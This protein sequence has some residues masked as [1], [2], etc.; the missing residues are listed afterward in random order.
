MST[1][2]VSVPFEARDLI[3]G[4]VRNMRRMIQGATDDLWDFR[5]A[6]GNMFDNFA[7]GS[8]RARESVEDLGRRINNAQDESRRLGNT[9]IDDLFRRARRGA[10]DLRS[11]I[12]RTDREIRGL[13]NK[14]IH[15][16][17]RDEVSPVLDNISSKMGTI[18][19]AASTLILGGGMKSAMFGGVKDYHAS[20]AR[21]AP[22]LTAADRDQGLSTVDELYKQGLF[23]SRAEGANQL[24]DAASLVQDKS[25][26]SDFLSQSAKMQKLNPDASPEEVN[27]ALAQATNVFKES[28]ESVGDS[29]MYARKNVGDRQQ[30]LNDTY[31]EYSGYFK[32]AGVNS[33]QMSNF[34]VQ[35]VQD[36]SFNFDKPADFFK[37]VFG[38]KALDA[39]DMS[40]YF[41]H[42]GVGKEEAARQAAVFTG[43]INSGNEQ[44]MKGAIMALV[45]DLASQ[46]SNDL[47]QSL[48]MLG[49]ATAEDNGISMI[50]NYGTAFKE[51]PQDIAGT[52]DIMMQQQLDANPMQDMIETKRQIELQMQEIG[53]N[54]SAEA[55]P[56]LKE[57]NSL[58]T[59]NKDSIESIGSGIAGFVS[60][61]TS[62]YKDHFGLINGI[63]GTI[64]GGFLLKKL[65]D[66]G[67]G[68]YKFGQDTKKI[69]EWIWTTG[70]S[71]FPR[72]GK[73]P[74]TIPESAH[75]VPVGEWT[76]GKSIPGTG[77]HS[78]SIPNAYP[79]Q[80]LLVKA[81]KVYI[82]GS[83]MRQWTEDGVGHQG[84]K[85][86]KTRRGPK[87]RKNGGEIHQS[88]KVRNK[89]DRTGNVKQNSTPPKNPPPK[90]PSS[91]PHPK[92]IP[93]RSDV[94][95][96]RPRPKLPDAP[97]HQG[98]MSA[99]PAKGIM[100]GLGLLG[101]VADVSMNAYNM[102]QT[103]QD[104]GWREAASTQGGEVVGGIAGGA[105]LGAVGSLVG[106]LGTAAGY[107]VGGW[108]GEKLGGLAD[109][110]GLTRKVVDG[111]IAVKDSVVSWTN[112]AADSIKGVFGDFTD[113]IGLT[114]KEESPAAPPAP[115]PEAKFTF[116]DITPEAEKRMNE[117]AG[118][119]ATTV[120]EKGWG[121][122]FSGVM[123]QP[124]VKDTIDGLKTIGTE[125]A[126]TF[127]VL[128]K[129][130][131]SQ[132][133]KQ[134]I[135]EVGTAAQ[136]TAAKT[137]DLGNKAK[138]AADETKLHLSSIETIISQGSGWGSNL[139]TMMTYGIRSKFP[140]LTSAVHEAAGVIN[141][142]LG[143]HSPTKEGPASKS[144]RWAGNFVSMF[145]SGLNARPIRERMHLIAGALR[146]QVTE[147]DVPGN[148]LRAD[149]EIPVSKTLN[150]GAK[151][152]VAGQV[153][154][155]NVNFDF[156]EMA[157]GVTNFTEFAKMMTS[158][159]GRAL[160]RKVLGEELYKAVESGG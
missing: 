125:V 29:M 135:D 51:A 160:I 10:D 4:A 8:R 88:S 19:A 58:I 142:F 93:H 139:I 151:P 43:D 70:A 124:E 79:V 47:K 96:H 24:A 20:A 143:F 148:S 66:F 31:W 94:D 72:T 55:L 111:A 159:D 18:A 81:S 130:G 119:F 11:S 110:V 89:K 59:E 115:P 127:S 3:S 42:R 157:K 69:G 140:F 39:G 132:N 120:K 101:T 68:V 6:S 48:V 114:S 32:N 21:S 64:T 53:S 57:F 67:K 76:V 113:W 65:Y 122:A 27:R 62:I 145:A 109:S 23:E 126:D 103:A 131:D 133:A 50:K 44:R 71:I 46:S 13:S 17:A 61:V 2:R 121:E 82:S 25:K 108:L 40:K 144:D 91:P 28:V 33:G 107:A 146:P 137:K 73:K 16:R 104:V 90:R 134:G 112:D 85:R 99:G 155:Q 26:V 49:S 147:Q 15:L 14:S 118:Q 30:D 74:K 153:T 52:T 128:W 9:H 60:G 84:K 95:L 80:M 149:T 123:E 116:G 100:K 97:L 150:Q 98:F 75:P 87:N 63:I 5:R 117:V 106:P 102:Y 56:V 36:G 78:K 83:V 86:C 152:V 22:Y 92:E 77:G 54:V 35:S 105:I 1:T 136:Q 138:S 154:I 129:G 38:V 12:N 45:A 41:E 37:E 141:D 158:S 34:L 156:G 7:S